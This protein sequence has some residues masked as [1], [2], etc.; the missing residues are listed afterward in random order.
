MRK[1]LPLLLCLL[2]LGLLYLWLLGLLLCFKLLAL[3]LLLL[4]K[5]CLLC[6]THSRC[7]ILWDYR[8]YCFG[9]FRSILTGF[10]KLIIKFCSLNDCTHGYFKF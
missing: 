4:F 3:E 7:C 10:C 5:L 1:I 2:L 8:L 9:F 6:G